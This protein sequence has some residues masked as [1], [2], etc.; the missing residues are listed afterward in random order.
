MPD[1]YDGDGLC[2]KVDPDDDGDGTPDTDDAFPFDPTENADLE[3]TA[4]VT[5][6]TPTTT[7][8]AGWTP[9]SP[10]VAPTRWTSSLCLRT[11]TA[12]TSA[13]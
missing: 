5:T 7:A 3:A 1:D 2:D 8:T 6:Q 9:R 12:T 4:L 13:T 10:T 11:T